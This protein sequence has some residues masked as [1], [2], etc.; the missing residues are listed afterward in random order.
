MS[1]QQRSFATDCPEGCPPADAV[2][3]NGDFFRLAHANPPSS[4]DYKTYAELGIFPDRDRCLRCGLS[5]FSNAKGAVSLYQYMMKRHPG[6]VDLGKYVA[7][8]GLHPT[9]G[10]VK[11]TN[12]PPHHTWWMHEGTDRAAT[13]RETVKELNHAQKH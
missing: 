6:A 12:R 1:A 2:D 9:D 4:E 5:V 8:L 7:R 13:F 3:A 11:Q 10:K